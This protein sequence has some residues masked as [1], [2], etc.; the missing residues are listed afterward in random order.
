MKPRRL[1]TLSAP[2]R[3]DI[4]KLNGAYEHHLFMY[5]IIGKTGGPLTLRLDASLLDTGEP[6]LDSEWFN[7][8]DD[9]ALITIN[10]DITD[11]IRI[12]DLP[13]TWL[14]PV[15]VAGAA[16][17]IEFWYAGSLSPFPNRTGLISG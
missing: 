9:N 7:A 11:G 8:A 14:N 5:R 4:I 12:T 3:F 16:T 15:W 2:G 10:V 6:T 13:A 17:T 1:T